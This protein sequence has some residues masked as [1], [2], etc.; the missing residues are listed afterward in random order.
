MQV[1]KLV[2]YVPEDHAEAVKRA[3]FEAGAGRMGNY[4][5]CAWQ[6]LG[7]GQFRPLA[8][9]DPFIGKQGEIERVPEYR[10]ETICMADCLKAVVAALRRAHPY[11]EP[12]FDVWK[13]ESID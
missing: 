6:V 5:A 8:G 13:L 11:E 4:E 1:Y 12:A 2:F 10:V 9:S 7:E 3:V